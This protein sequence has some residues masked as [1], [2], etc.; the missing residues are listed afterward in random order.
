MRRSSQEEDI[1]VEDLMFGVQ[2]AEPLGDEGNNSSA[3]GMQ[4]DEMEQ[5]YGVTE[6][7]QY[8]AAAAAAGGLVEQQIGDGWEED[9]A[10]ELL[11]SAASMDAEVAAATVVHCAQANG[12]VDAVGEGS[13]DA[14]ENSA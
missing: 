4:E 12:G 6:E 2:H 11:E 5:D 13:E 1:P 10:V 7:Q 3:G 14:V 8:A 9:G